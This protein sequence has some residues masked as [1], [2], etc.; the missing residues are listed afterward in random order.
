MYEK[1]N[2]GSNR[3]RVILAAALI[4][5]LAVLL[6]GCSPA[7]GKLVQ[8]K[9][10]HDVQITSEGPDYGVTVTATI[11]NV[12]EAGSLMISPEISTSEGEWDRTQHLHF[13]ANETKT[14]T[15]FFPEPSLDAGNIQY[16][17]SVFP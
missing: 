11:K 7:E 9:A 6:T 2:A 16:E 13:A 3:A 15:W 5:S 12:G 10:K 1:K 8:V 4:V 17:V 14:L